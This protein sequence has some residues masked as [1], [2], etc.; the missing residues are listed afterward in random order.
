[1]KF[2]ISIIFSTISFIFSQNSALLFDGVDDYV[3]HGNVLHMGS[4]FSVG[5]WAYSNG[6]NGVILSKHLF[7]IDSNQPW[8][9][10]L[11]IFLVI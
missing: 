8:E 4:S 11:V 9:N 5:A 2:Y 3:N 6:G 7:D 1:M 10:I